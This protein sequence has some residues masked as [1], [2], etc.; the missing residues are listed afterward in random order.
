MDLFQGVLHAVHV[1][2]ERGEHGENLPDLLLSLNFRLKGDSLADLHPDS[3]CF[4]D[5]GFIPFFKPK[6]YFL[7]TLVALHFNPVSK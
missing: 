7:A 4:L 5:H 3:I 6:L 1:S 2:G